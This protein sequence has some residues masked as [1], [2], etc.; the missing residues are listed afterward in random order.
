LTTE[1]RGGKLI[2][3]QAPVVA[4]DPATEIAPLYAQIA[5][6]LRGEIAAGA[7]AVGARIPSEH[8]LAARFAVGRPTV[9]QAIDLLAREHLLERRRGSGTYVGA[10]P[11]EIDLFSAGGTVASL[12]RTG[13]EAEARLLGRMVRRAVPASAS[14]PFAGKTAFFIARRSRIDGDPVLLE[15]MYFAPAAFPDLDKVAIE[16]QSLSR[17]ARERFLLRTER[18]EQRF[19]LS[20]LDGLRGQR[21]GL[22]PGLVVLKVE[23]TIDFFGAPCGF[24]AELYCRADR[25]VFTQELDVGRSSVHG[26]APSGPPARLP[27]GGPGAARRPVHLAPRS[28]SSDD[29]QRRIP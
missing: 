6:R 17:I 5:A 8:E 12:E 20:A 28:R 29:K 14:H 9:R 21:F 13:L 19:R 26:R 3:V 27:A 2:L 10:P 16:G 23:R 11:P 1:G 7:Y 25:V 24:F 18:V 15:E 22:E 4:L